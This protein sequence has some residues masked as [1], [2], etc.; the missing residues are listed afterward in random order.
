MMSVT[1]QEDLLVR[2]RHEADILCVTQ[3]LQWDWASRRSNSDQQPSTAAASMDFVPLVD[4]DDRMDR[5][6]L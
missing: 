6:P 3:R 2:H 4:V 1:V 5:L